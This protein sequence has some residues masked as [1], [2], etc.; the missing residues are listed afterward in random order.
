MRSLSTCLGMAVV[1]PFCGRE[2]AGRE[3]SAILSGVLCIRV[4]RG[5]I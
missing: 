5:L 3:S 1:T 4:M 2:L